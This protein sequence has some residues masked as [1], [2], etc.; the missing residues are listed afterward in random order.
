MDK[1]IHILYIDDDIENLI[2]FETSLSNNFEIHT[3]SNISEIDKIID[4]NPIEVIILD[5]K[6][7]EINGIE[8]ND[9]LSQK[10]PDKIYM[11]TSAY[12]DMEIVVEAINHHDI[13]GFIPKP[14]NFTELILL[15]KNASKLY[16]SQQQN[17]SLL[18]QLKEKNELLEKTNALKTNFLKN[19]SHEI[20]TPI[21]AII[22]FN[23]IARD[24]VTC[25]KT[26][27]ALSYSLSG[28]YDLLQVITNIV[29]ASK[30]LTNQASYFIRNVNVHELIENIRSS[31]IS[32]EELNI[33]NELPPDL[34]LDTDPYAMLEIF[35]CLIDNALKFAKKGDLRIFHECKNEK[36]TFHFK[37]NGPGVKESALEYIFEP[38][39]QEDE[40][41]IRKYGGTGLGLFIA[42]SHTE[43]LNGMMSIISEKEKGADFIITLPCKSSED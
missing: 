1:D 24:N 38:F 32:N 25:E 42:K 31:K 16:K 19:I 13:Y 22:G 26:K 29:N 35:E 12:A 41:D 40:S 30:L 7:P 5:Y 28:C 20:R 36:I 8:L 37:D 4:E 15:I 6:M 14:W 2:G 23:Q 33:S 9:Q 21:N 43:N 34:F 10:Y 11:I 27:K 17:K 39:R 18:Q 3:T